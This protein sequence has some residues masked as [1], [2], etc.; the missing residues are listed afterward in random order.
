MATDMTMV[1]RMESNRSINRCLPAPVVHWFPSVFCL[2]KAGILQF[3]D[4]QNMQAA[5]L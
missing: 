2:Q 1:D 5:F 4:D 3:V